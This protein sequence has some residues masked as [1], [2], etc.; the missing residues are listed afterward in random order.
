MQNKCNLFHVYNW[1][2]LFVSMYNNTTTYNNDFKIGD[3][4]VI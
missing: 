2:Q 3:E 4:N 1:K